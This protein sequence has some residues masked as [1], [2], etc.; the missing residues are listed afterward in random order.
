MLSRTSRPDELEFA[1]PRTSR[2]PRAGLVPWLAAALVVAG[3]VSALPA[4]AVSPTLVPA[5]SSTKGDLK[6]V[7][8]GM[9]SGVA[10][11]VVV[12]KA[13]KALSPIATGTRTYSNLTPGS[14]V[15]TAT[16]V[17]VAK[18]TMVP[19]PKTRTLTVVKNKTVSAPVKYTF[20]G[21][22]VTVSTTVN[23][24]SPGWTFTSSVTTMAITVTNSSKKRVLTSF[25][26]VVPTGVPAPTKAVVA[27]SSKRAW[28]ATITRCGSVTHCVKRIVVTAKTPLSTNRLAYAQKAIVTLTL[29]SPSVS[30]T[31][32]FL[33]RNIGAGYFTVSGSEASLRT[34]K[35]TTIL[36]E[37]GTPVPET[38]VQI[39][40][41]P[42][43]TVST[44]LAN[45]AYGPVNLYYEPAPCL[46][47]TSGQCATATLD[48]T[49]SEGANHLYGYGISPQPLAPASMTVTC[50]ATNCPRPNTVTQISAGLDSSCVLESDSTVW[51][52]GSNKN[53]QLGT[54]LNF[55][56][57]SPNSTPLPVDG[58]PAISSVAV[59]T[60]HA[61]AIAS[62]T[63]DV[64][65][66]GNNN[67]GQLGRPPTST[68][69]DVRVP[70]QVP[71]V[72]GATTISAGQDFTCA[73]IAANTLTCWGW[74][75]YGQLGVSTSNGTNDPVAP[76]SVPN[77]AG[78]SAV[79]A[80]MLHTCALNSQGTVFCW[81][82]NALGQLGNTTNLGVTAA[83]YQPTNVGISG[84]TAISAA[85]AFTCALFPVDGSANC[86]GDDSTGQLGSAKPQAG[87]TAIPTPVVL[88]SGGIMTGASTLS[89]GA[90]SLTDGHA[91][92]TFGAGSAASGTVACWGD[93]TY[94]QAGNTSS[95]P[96]F[97]AT[98]VNGLYFADSITSGGL[99]T[100]V[101]RS[102]LAPECWGWN[103]YGQLGNALNT[104]TDLPDSTPT[105]VTGFY[106]DTRIAE[107]NAYPIYVS[108]KVSGVYQPY[109]PAT[110]CNAFSIMDSI[111]GIG[112]IGP[113]Q[114]Q[115]DGFCIDVGAISRNVAQGDVLTRTILF[116]EDPKLTPISR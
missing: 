58:L 46:P 93:N 41:D 116:A 7:V 100:C 62:S 107:Y 12:T 44:T 81:G 4:S 34:V 18:G 70:V 85:G 8:S 11:K 24:K 75:R 115:T 105:A 60:Q 99:T 55:H 72:T 21:Q 103:Y 96:A 64:W 101:H 19:S 82:D 22:P 50:S 38:A 68:A 87:F 13:G 77:L 33:L 37:P 52:F 102:T 114:P 39:G 106:D 57:S 94:G 66:W 78:I 65:C 51:C 88:A 16:N 43:N 3:T 91:C 79:S 71:G 35:G 76:T 84:V 89:A 27:A 98:S 32:P 86:W 9:P 31:S 6:V 92:V 109:K 104:A 40:T 90:S 80:G 26:I 112:V 111:V 95:T 29:T 49:F 17:S 108:L 54:A 30:G 61:C 47:G 113:G 25:E 15:V 2:H 110:P 42:Q 28:K 73:V 20:V 5:V 69:N 45:G 97:A 1:M 14:Y 53:G 74:N 48:G 10:A 67:F 56:K 36:A 63:G 59:G 23:K 83:N